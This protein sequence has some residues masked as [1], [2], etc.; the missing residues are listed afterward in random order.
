MVTPYPLNPAVLKRGI[1]HVCYEYANLIS[2]AYWSING[3]APWRTNVDD[4]FLLG[5]RKLR[6][7]LFKAKRSER[8]GLE[9]PDILASDYLPRG[10]APTWTLP[11]WESEWQTEIDKQLAHITFERDKEW[12]HEKWAPPLELEMRTA[13][14]DFLAVVEA[15]HKPE[16]AAQ[17]AHCQGKPGFRALRL[18]SC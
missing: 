13:W 7:F 9:L 16:F 17:L 8:K 6:D 1:E 14:A 3:E 15:Q 4:A 10:F 18:W 12:N 2:A 11:T 5:Y